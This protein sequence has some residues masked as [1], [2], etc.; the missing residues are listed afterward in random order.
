MS[1]KSDS[2][3]HRSHDDYDRHRNNRPR[4]RSRSPEIRN[5]KKDGKSHRSE[6]SSGSHRRPER[7]EDVWRKPERKGDNHRRADREEPIVR[8]IKSEPADKGYRKYEFPE[9]REKEKESRSRWDDD[10]KVEN[11]RQGGDRRGSR[12]EVPQI[13]IK[14]EREHND[15]RRREHRQQVG[16]ANPFQTTDQNAGE[17]APP[18][19]KEEPN[20][21]L[22][23]ALTED[24]NTF[25]GIVIKYNEP[26]EARKPKL[27]WR[28]YVFKGDQELPT[29][30]IHR[31]SA[32]L[33]G[34]ERLIADLPIDHPSCSK[35]HAA[36]QYRLVEYEKND[37]T[38]GKRVRPY[39]IDL[40]SANGTFL[41]NKQIEPKRYYEMKEKDVLKFGFSS[42]EYVVLH[43]KTTAGDI[44]DEGEI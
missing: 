26:P 39:I 43:D 8:K 20:F 37:G 36:I 2:R 14:Q 27:R 5:R 9:R 31:Q 29:L 22:S 7:E 33:L 32:Y 44:E 30:Y 41:N 6:K 16:D 28:L 11:T 23:G 4:S 15:E 35:Q 21:G 13:R 19:P 25:R 3:K 18:A 1:S 40:E 38:M 24:T 12:Q 17:N 10:D 42:R 34:R